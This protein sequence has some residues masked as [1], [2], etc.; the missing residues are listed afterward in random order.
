MVTQKRNQKAVQQSAPSAGKKPKKYK[1][2][3]TG[4]ANKGGKPE[5]NQQKMSEY[6]NINQ[7]DYDDNNK[8]PNDTDDNFDDLEEMDEDIQV[9]EPLE[10]SE[11][12]NG[13]STELRIRKG[14]EW[15]VVKR[16]Y[17]KTKHNSAN[18]REN[19]T[20]KDRSRRERDPTPERNNSMNFRFKTRVTVRMTIPH[21]P[22][23][24]YEPVLNAVQEFVQKLDEV[25]KDCAL[26]PWRQ[27][28]F[29][30]GKLE[31]I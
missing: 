21:S 16:K 4:T 18:R 22:D 2:S 31:K 19:L 20:E 28:S 26:L 8:Q 6:N 13:T 27:S 14:S 5:Q 10:P 3:T 29:Y 1:S 30:K 24:I 12:R 23:D 15:Q 7:N 17:K 11:L 25:E 9:A